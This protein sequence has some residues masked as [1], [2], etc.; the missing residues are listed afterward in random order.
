MPTVPRPST[1]PERCESSPLREAVDDVMQ[2][3]AGGVVSHPE[4]DK[5]I[6]VL[7]VLQLSLCETTSVE[8]CKYGDIS[9]PTIFQEFCK[10]QYF[11]VFC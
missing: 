11:F 6:I 4:N 2:E 10:K 7:F 9:N 3:E 8:Y 5:T 1:H